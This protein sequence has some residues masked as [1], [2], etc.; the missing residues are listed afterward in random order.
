MLAGGWGSQFIKHGGSPQGGTG[1]RRIHSRR[2]A[3]QRARRGPTLHLVRSDGNVR[4][5]LVR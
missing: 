2:P 1:C 5:P 4:L 3:W